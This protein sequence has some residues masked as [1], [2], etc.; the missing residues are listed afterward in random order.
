MVIDE[1]KGWQKKCIVRWNKMIC[2]NVWCKWTKGSIIRYFFY[3][4]KIMHIILDLIWGN[5]NGIY[6]L[7]VNGLLTNVIKDDSKKTS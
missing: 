6:V 5:L 2:D 4:P 1:Y 3:F 7:T